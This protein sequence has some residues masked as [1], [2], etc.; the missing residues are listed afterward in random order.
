MVDLSPNVINN[1]INKKGAQTQM[2]RQNGR[3]D[4]KKNHDPTICCIQEIHLRYK[5]VSIFK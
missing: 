2:K 1:S 4:K 5:S 3:T